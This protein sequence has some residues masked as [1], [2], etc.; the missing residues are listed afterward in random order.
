MAPLG[1]AKRLRLLKP[2]EFDRVMR[3]RTS[4]VDGRLR[5]YGVANELGHPR[6]GLTVSRRVGNS[7]VRNRWKRALREAFRLV[8]HDLPAFDLVCIP[9]RNVEPNVA[10]LQESLS[11]LAR[12]IDEQL[13]RR[14]DR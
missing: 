2:S 5:M 12:R 14:R 9:H 4:A 10:R 13:G 11:K 6:L 1:F 8:Q 3:A 7:V